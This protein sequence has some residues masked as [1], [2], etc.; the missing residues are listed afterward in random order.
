MLFFLSSILQKYDYI[1]STGLVDLDFVAE[2]LT[3]LGFYFFIALTFIYYLIKKRLYIN[4]NCFLLLLKQLQRDWG[5]RQKL[6]AAL[7]KSEGLLREAQQIGKLGSWEYDCLTKKAL[8]SS[9]IFR[10]HGLEPKLEAID[11]HDTLKFIHPDDIE[12]HIK[13]VNQSITDKKRYDNNIR[14]IRKDGEVRYLKTSGEPLFN[15]EGVLISFV[16]SVIDITERQQSEFALKESETR[17]KLAL[18]ATKTICWERDLTNNQ[19]FSLGSNI[20]RSNGFQVS[21]LEALKFIHPDDREKVKV[22][23][24][25]A[26]DNLSTFEIE[27]RISWQGKPQQY[28]W[29]LLRGKV[30]ADVMGKPTRV[31]GVLVDITASKMITQR[32]SE[33]AVQLEEALN[34]LQKA[35]SRLVLSEKMASLGNLVA[36]VAHEINN[37]TSFIYSNIDPAIQYTQDLL[38]LIQLYQKHYP[39]PVTEIEEHIEAIDLDFITEDFPKLLASMREGANRIAGIVQS[40]RNFSRR[41]FTEPQRFDIH[42]GIDNTLL[43]LQHRLK[44]QSQRCEIKVI[45]EYSQLPKVECFP[46]LLNQVFM[47]LLSN[48]VDA[49]EESIANYKTENPQISIHTKLENEGRVLITIT[50]NGPGITEQVRKCIFDPFFTT[51]P[52][53]KGTG[54]GLSISYQIIV[55]RH[56]G[57]LQCVSEPGQGTSFIIDIPLQQ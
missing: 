11:Y 53:G 36:G 31:I 20:D 29:V 45:K 22:I 39:K 34:S 21:Y 54:M 15:N 26:I 10:I 30:I 42:F 38:S 37:P 18:E 41:D 33:K 2:G 6:S 23:N 56:Q 28:S 16:G 3:E 13:L 40:L 1:F 57:K 19:V 50:D 55:E 47:N 49:L 12:D 14:I 25:Q 44:E 48:A 4:Y 27:H 7:Q 52:V 35:Q 17:L 5:E 8:W 46:G 43:L 24:Q 9:E 51:K 32:E